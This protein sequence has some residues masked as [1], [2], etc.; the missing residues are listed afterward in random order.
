MRRLYLSLSALIFALSVVAQ[1]AVEG[2]SYYLPKTA[3][4]ITVLVEKTTFTP[5]DFAV[6]SERYL[7]ESAAAEA[8]SSFRI[9]DMQLETFGTPD[10][11]KVY[12]AHID[13]K[14]S[15]TSIDKDDNGVLIAVNAKGKRQ[16]K[17]TPFK[18]S[19]KE[20]PLSPRD[21]MTQDMLAAGS[22]AK[23]AE[24]TALE[25]Y[26]IRD[27]KNMLNR[28]EADFMPQDGAQL[29]L[30]LSNLDT[31]ERAL[32]QLFKGIT[33]RDTAEV[34]IV[35]LPE[36]ETVS[37]VLFRFST[38]IGVVDKDDL[39]GV[40]YYITLEDLD[41]RPTLTVNEEAAKQVKGSG[42]CV[43]LPGKIRVSITKD[44]ETVKSYE[45]YAAQYGYTEELSAGLFGSRFTSSVVLS[46]VTGNAESLVTEQL[47]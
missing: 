46:P 34:E 35:Y 36:K 33:A 44:A 13:R 38:K 28:G 22:T 4:R 12:T 23:M 19:P 43:N 24:L 3:L 30:M 8:S 10:T 39:A 2:I 14:L 31:Q 18:P 20:K 21:Y 17:H 6:Y 47:K 45:L 29:R 25:I 7:R 15:I 32:T 11:S 42:V 9:V 5:G 1:N 27:S 26:D 37:D 40:P 16:E 41:I